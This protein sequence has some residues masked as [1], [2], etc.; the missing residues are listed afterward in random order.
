MDAPDS[1]EDWIAVRDDPFQPRAPTPPPLRFEVRWDSVAECVA[2]TCR[3]RSSCGDDDAGWSR[4]L[5][6]HQLRCVH[7]QLCLVRPSLADRPP[8][9]LPAHPRGIWAYVRHRAPTPASLPADL[10]RY[11]ADA[12]DT[13]GQAVLLETLFGEP[14]PDEYFEHISE[15]RRRLYDDAVAVAYDCLL[16]VL[17]LR[18]GSVNMLDMREAYVLEDDAVYRWNLA[19]ASLYNYLVQPFLDLRELAGAKVR[20]A[21]AGLAGREDDLDRSEF[22]AM[23]G[24]W[25][26]HYAGA[27]DSIQQLYIIYYGN[28]VNMLSGTHGR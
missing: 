25:Q 9:R 12:V 10:Q 7:K 5:T 19:V 26:T 8:P 20:E 15:L 11:L 14:S 4:Q 27:V 24:E 13:V 6:S 2:V 23:F 21:R 1:L 16:N 17:F 18:D 22:T 3:P 28:T